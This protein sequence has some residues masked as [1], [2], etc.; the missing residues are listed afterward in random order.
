MSCEL[1]NKEGGCADW[2]KLSKARAKGIDLEKILAFVTPCPKVREL[3]SVHL[4]SKLD[5]SKTFGVDTIIL[6]KKR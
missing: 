1:C 4:K 6:H 2:E 3:S 5:T